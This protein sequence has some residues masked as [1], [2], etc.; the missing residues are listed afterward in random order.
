[1]LN[2]AVYRGNDGLLLI[3]EQ[4]KNNMGS[5]LDFRQKHRLQDITVQPARQGVPALQVTGA[6]FQR[7]HWDG[8]VWLSWPSLKSALKIAPDKTPGEWLWQ[9]NVAVVNLSLKF[10]FGRLAIRAQQ[11][12]S[13]RLTDEDKE[14]GKCLT[15]SSLSVPALL[16][17]SFRSAYTSVAQKGLLDCASDRAAMKRVCDALL[18]LVPKSFGL[19]S[20]AC[21][22]S[23]AI[24]RGT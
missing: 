11:P 8:H 6:I 9:R 7:W 10:G 15:F 14:Q 21:F 4:G 17:L 12:Y 16:L 20:V 13:D 22:F 5:L 18:D 19:A 2:A 1:M 23:R 24:L 3:T